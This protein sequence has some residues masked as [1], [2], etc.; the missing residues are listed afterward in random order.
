MSIVCYKIQKVSKN[1]SFFVKV[2]LYSLYI[3]IKVHNVLKHCDLRT[4]NKIANL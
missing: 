1:K 3:L 2:H 4:L